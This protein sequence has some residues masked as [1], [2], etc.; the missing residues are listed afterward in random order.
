M[1]VSPRSSTDFSFVP[2]MEFEEPEDTEPD[3]DSEI[4][5]NPLETESFNDSDTGGTTFAS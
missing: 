2:D 1:N 5:L 3:L 4:D